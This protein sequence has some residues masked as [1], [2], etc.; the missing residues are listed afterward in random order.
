MSTPDPAS[1]SLLDPASQ[2]VEPAIPA[3]TVV[4]KEETRDPAPVRRGR[5]FALRREIP[6]WQSFLFA[7]IFLALVA[8]VWFGVTRGE[9]TEERL[10]RPSV[11]PSPE[12]TF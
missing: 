8:A 4:R 1:K 2:S 5:F 10:V 6:L 9:T 12:E 7:A 11:L 3:D